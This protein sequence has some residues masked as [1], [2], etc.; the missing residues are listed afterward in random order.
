MSQEKQIATADGT[1]VPVAAEQ[2]RGIAGRDN[3]EPR[4][5]SSRWLLESRE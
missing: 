3:L 4:R 1:A 2:L 5:Q